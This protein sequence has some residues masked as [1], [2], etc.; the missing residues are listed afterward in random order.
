MFHY[1]NAP[2]PLGAVYPAYCEAR[3]RLAGYLQD[4]AAGRVLDDQHRTLQLHL[5]LLA[6]RTAWIERDRPNPAD[7][8]DEEGATASVISQRC[9]LAGDGS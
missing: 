7:L 4:V 6:A 2:A 1:D 3:S 5:E 9:Q 8:E